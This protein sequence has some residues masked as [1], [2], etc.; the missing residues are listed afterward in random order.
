M[1]KPKEKLDL[2]QPDKRSHAVFGFLLAAFVVPVAWWFVGLGICKAFKIH[3]KYLPAF[4]VIQT[5]LTSALGWACKEWWDTG[6]SPFQHFF[7]KVIP[8]GFSINDW[9]ASMLGCMIAAAL[10]AVF[11]CYLSSIGAIKEMMYPEVLP[12]RDEIHA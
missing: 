11:L 7:P 12:V 1:T 8:T 4:V 5:V 3:V 10:W 6:A 2:T 9:Y